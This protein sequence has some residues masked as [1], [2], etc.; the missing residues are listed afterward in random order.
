MCNDFEMQMHLL[1]PDSVYFL[2]G[3]TTTGRR[4]LQR[5]QSVDY[6]PRPSCKRCDPPSE[7]TDP[8]LSKKWRGDTDDLTDE[9]DDIHDDV[10]DN[11]VR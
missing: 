9:S 10:C 7:N 5:S 1:K 11:M 8:V 4:K 3:C 6:R 2:Q